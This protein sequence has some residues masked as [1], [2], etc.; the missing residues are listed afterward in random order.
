MTMHEATGVLVEKRRRVRWATLRDPLLY[1]GAASTYVA[2]GL[3]VT[4]FRLTWVVA[5]VWLLLWVWLLPAAVRRVA[6]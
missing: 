4:W 5:F 1:G 6:R 2:I 3:F